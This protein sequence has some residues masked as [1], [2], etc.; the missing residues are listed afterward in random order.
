MLKDESA[1][2]GISLKIGVS[3]LPG[4]FP[5]FDETEPFTGEGGKRVYGIKSTEVSDS[6]SGEPSKGKGGVIRAID[7]AWN[8]ANSNNLDIWMLPELCLDQ[9]ALNHLSNRLTG[10]PNS[11]YP[12]VVLPGTTY[13]QTGASK[14]SNRAPIW[15]RAGSGKWDFTSKYYNKRIPFGMNTNVSDKAPQDIREISRKAESRGVKI[16][17]EHFERGNEVVTNTINGVKCGI[18]VC[19]DVLDVFDDR[20]PLFKYNRENKVDL[21]LVTSMNSGHTNLFTATAESMARWHNCATVYINNFTSVTDDQN[22]T[23]ELS[24]AFLPDTS[25]V[26]GIKGFIYYRKLPLVVTGKD[27]DTESEPEVDSAFE[28]RVTAIYSDSVRALPIPL[29][30]NVLYEISNGNFVNPRIL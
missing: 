2:A 14:H 26:A 7:N 17:E 21:M 18:A 4:V 15:V 8:W 19:R 12:K 9:N 25:R 3:T 28:N 22:N 16:L 11:N 23:V 13:V 1:S 6:Q 27:S 20:N 10:S 30:G 29:G 5:R 24:F